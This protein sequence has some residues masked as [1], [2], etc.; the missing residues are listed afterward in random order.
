ME[1]S[2]LQFRV[3]GLEAAVQQ[4]FEGDKGPLLQLARETNDLTLEKLAYEQPPFI[5]QFE[6]PCAVWS[7]VD[8]QVCCALSLTWADRMGQP[9][10]R[11]SGGEDVTVAIM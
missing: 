7:E 9:E 2:M 6:D 8:D 4:A 1:G 3:E 5:T 10:A 11:R